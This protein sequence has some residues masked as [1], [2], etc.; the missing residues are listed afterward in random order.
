L[1]EFIYYY[2]TKGAKNL[3]EMT[4]L[5]LKND[6]RAKVVRLIR[7][8]KTENPFLGIPSKEA[9]LLITL[10][11]AMRDNNLDLGKKTITLLSQEIEKTV[12]LLTTQ[13]KRNA[14]SY[15]VSIVGV[16]LTIIF[17]IISLKTLF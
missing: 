6:T 13:E 4:E 7:V 8:A 14:V 3:H 2:D 11:Q 17:G 1:E 10:N 12:K 5:E 16:I 9:N 15:I